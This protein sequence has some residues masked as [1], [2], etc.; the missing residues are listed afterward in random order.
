M[1]IDCSPTATRVVDRDLI[2]RKLADLDLYVTQ[3]APY[4]ALDVAGY[5]ADWRTQRIVERTL[6]LAI[7]TCM[8]VADHLVADRRLKVPETGAA[9]FESL[10]EAKMLP[11]WR[12]FLFCGADLIRSA[13]RAFGRGPHELQATA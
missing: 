9:T 8:D 2:L 6:H 3:L 4:R 11:S 13:R 12:G 10:G 7:E 5:N 1:S